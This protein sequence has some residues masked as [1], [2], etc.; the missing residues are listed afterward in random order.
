MLAGIDREEGES[1]G[2]ARVDVGRGLEMVGVR[3]KAALPAFRDD[4][5]ERVVHHLLRRA[6]GPPHLADRL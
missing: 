1:G 4:T 2:Q 6:P 5:P 3:P